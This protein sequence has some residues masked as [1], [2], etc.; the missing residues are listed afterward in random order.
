[1]KYILTALGGAIVGAG[2]ALLLAPQSG[3]STRSFLKQKAT[4]YAHEI[5][6]F[7]ESKTRHLRNKAKGI[8]H[9]SEEAMEKS[10]EMIDRGREMV[11]AGTGSMSTSSDGSMGQTTL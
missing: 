10:Q 6:D 11:G 8:R 2:A 1:M 7:T 9:T 3:R 5:Q 4:K